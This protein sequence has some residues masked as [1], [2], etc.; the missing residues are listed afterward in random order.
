M[1]K[2]ALGTIVYVV[3]VALA[4]FVPIVYGLDTPRRLIIVFKFS[5]ITPGS[6][7]LAFG[8]FQTLL[9]DKQLILLTEVLKIPQDRLELRIIS[10]GAPTNLDDYWRQSD[11]LVVMVGSLFQAGDLASVEVRAFLGDLKD[12]LATPSLPLSFQV[13]TNEFRTTKDTYSLLTTFALAM[14]AERLHEPTS[15]VIRYLSYAE[16]LALDLVKGPSPPPE[17]Q[18]LLTAVRQHLATLKRRPT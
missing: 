7:E 18:A 11:S 9:Y 16:D 15:T 13:R 2:I 10:T 1:R 6:A 3:A 8:Q 17:A 4:G 14:D 12:G 5:G